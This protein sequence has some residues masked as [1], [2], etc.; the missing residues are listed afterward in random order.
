MIPISDPTPEPG[1]FLYKEKHG[2]LDWTLH[3]GHGK[4]TTR[5]HKYEASRSLGH[6][7]PCNCPRMAVIP[8]SRGGLA[9][10]LYQGPIQNRRYSSIEKNM[11]FWIGAYI[12]IQ[13][14]TGGILL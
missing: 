9:G 5:Q 3:K 10:A 7:G 12:N 11:R 1:C 6:H 14:R 13:S 4:G 2:V 8:D